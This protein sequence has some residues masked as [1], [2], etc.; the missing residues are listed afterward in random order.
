MV[1]KLSTHGETFQFHPYDNT[2]SPNIILPGFSAMFR[3][4]GQLWTDPVTK[5][6]ILLHR[7]QKTIQYEYY[8][9]SEDK[10]IFYSRMKLLEVHR[11]I[12]ESKRLYPFEPL[13]NTKKLLN[14]AL[15]PDDHHDHV[16]FQY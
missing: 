10:R 9:M 5:T 16:F 3:R 12:V 7:R 15:I 13:Y 14:S 1:L 2:P 8:D 11:K 4:R 6:H